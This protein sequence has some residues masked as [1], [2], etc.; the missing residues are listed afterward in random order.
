MT[1]G[2]NCELMQDKSLRD[3]LNAE[4]NPLGRAEKM[5]KDPMSG[6]PGSEIQSSYFLIHICTL[7]L[8]LTLFNNAIS[9]FFTL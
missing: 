9:I 5:Y 6:P 3:G 2:N 4:L 1:V 7:R 8:N